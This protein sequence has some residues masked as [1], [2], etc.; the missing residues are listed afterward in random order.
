MGGSIEVKSKLGQGSTF[1][2]T[3]PFE[4]AEAPESAA[5]EPKPKKQ[6][7]QGIAEMHFLV[8]EDNDLNAD[9]ITMILEDQ[10]ATLKLVTDGSKAVEE[11]NSM[12]ADTYDA[13]LMDVMMPVMDGLTATRKIRALERPDSKTIPIIAMTANAFAE[14][15]HNCLEAGMN[16]YLTKPLDVNKL[17]DVLSK[18]R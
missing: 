11:F 4:I 7:P 12:P 1:I 15:R 14:D 16:S 5:S 18:L 17:I 3:I 9:I 2:V 10:G 13:I 6:K 8:A